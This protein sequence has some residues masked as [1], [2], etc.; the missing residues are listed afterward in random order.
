MSDDHKDNHGGGG[1]EGHAEGHGK[2]HGG[3]GHGHGGGSHEEHEG[4]PEWLISFA[5]NVALLMG[6][7]VI[8]LAMN[9][10]KP[11]A[12]GIGGEGKYPS[13]D[14]NAAMLDFA[15]SV[16]NAFNTPPD[17][18][19][20]NDVLLIKRM[21]ER[22]KRGESSDPGPDGDQKS[23]QAPR[24]SDYVNIA[25]FVTFADQSA[26]LS[27]DG[28]RTLESVAEKVR[29][30]S[31]MIEVRGHV[32][33]QEARQDKER[34]M[35]LAYSRAYAA[36]DAMSRFGVSWDVMRVVACGDNERA[37]PRATSGEGHKNNQR[38]EVVITQEQKPPDPFASVETGH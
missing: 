29:G 17:E 20:P 38:V 5:D 33:A 23:V 27:E 21:R 18:S 2:S 24:A 6:F 28:D 11:T 22:E 7:F 3:G 31:F 35:R 16:R 10:A 30:H 36:A 13:D 9:M 12:G 8:L 34:A 15:I 19:N 26:E 32:S 4:A 1:S 25:G 37:T 14:E